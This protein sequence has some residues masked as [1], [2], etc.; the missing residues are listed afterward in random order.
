MRSTRSSQRRMYAFQITSFSFSFGASKLN[1]CPLRAS[2]A[3]QACPAGEVSQPSLTRSVQLRA[4]LRD[5]LLMCVE[6]ARRGEPET[7]CKS[8]WMIR[9]ASRSLYRGLVGVGR[10]EL[11]G[12]FETGFSEEA[13]S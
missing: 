7:V 12:M 2:D 11:N 8:G 4:R 6:L 13:A 1:L 5:S 3:I 9:A 10:I